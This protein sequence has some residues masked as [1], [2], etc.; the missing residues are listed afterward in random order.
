MAIGTARGARESS[1]CSN[2]VNEGGFGRSEDAKGATSR[3]QIIEDVGERRRKSKLEIRMAGFE[4]KEVT[5]VLKNV[6]M[7]GVNLRQG[8]NELANQLVSVDTWRQKISSKNHVG[9]YGEST[10]SLRL[11]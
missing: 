1:L 6:D 9:C 11:V 8:V 10:T 7:A 3:A 2:R 4:P 5:F